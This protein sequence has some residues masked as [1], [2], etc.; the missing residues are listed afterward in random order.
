MEYWAGGSRLDLE[1]IQPNLVVL[2][3]NSL[4]ELRPFNES[5]IAILCRELL[6]G[7]AE[8]IAT[9][10]PPPAKHRPPPAP[11]R[12]LIDDNG[13]IQGNNLPQVKN[14]LL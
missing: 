8:S 2:E 4:V 14:L 7:F 13:D 11:S 5:D 6:L 3:L 1:K 12:T 9:M 10:V